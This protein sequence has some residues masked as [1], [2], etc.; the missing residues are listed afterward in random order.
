[1]TSDITE[2]QWQR[3]RVHFGDLAYEH[4][5]LHRA[6]LDLLDAKDLDG[7]ERATKEMRADFAEGLA[8]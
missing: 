3:L 4:P 8:V 7:A 5:E 6:M 2:E 1:M